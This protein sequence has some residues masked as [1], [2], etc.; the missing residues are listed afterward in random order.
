MFERALIF[1]RYAEPIPSSREGGGLATPQ[2]SDAHPTPPRSD[3]AAQAILGGVA[4]NA[5]LTAL[6][7]MVILML[8]FLEGW[9]LPA[10][11]A[12]LTV[13]VFLGFLLIPPILLK[14]ASTGYRFVRYYTRNAD[15]RAAGPP[16][17]LLRLTAPVLVA[18]VAGLM[19]TGIALLVAGP[20]GGELWRRLHILT[21]LLWFG[22]MTIHVLAYLGRAAQLTLDDLGQVR[23]RLAVPGA[24]LRQSFVAGSIL[25]GVAIAL[26]TIPFDATWVHWLSLFHGDQ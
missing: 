8:F 20:Q 12:M 25:L 22:V 14:L 16:R 7:G 4:G 18:S 17:P 6:T 11:R 24:G 3:S 23:K 26:A 21:F 1:A 13:H 5:R 19:I 10:I 15:Y 2:Y 9:T